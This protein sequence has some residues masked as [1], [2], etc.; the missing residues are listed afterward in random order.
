MPKKPQAKILPQWV[1]YARGTRDIKTF[2]NVSGL[3]QGGISEL[4]TGE[5]LNPTFQT[6]VK[7]AESSQGRCLIPVLLIDPNKE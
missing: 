1:R 4:E 3:S 2:A 6:L 7:I 5:S